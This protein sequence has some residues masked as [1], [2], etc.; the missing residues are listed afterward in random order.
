[1]IDWND[2]AKA[3]VSAYND[4]A[5]ENDLAI[6]AFFEHLTN[7]GHTQPK[8]VADAVEYYG[9]TFV[10]GQWTH[11]RC[12]KDG[13]MFFASGETDSDNW[14]DSY[15][16]CTRAEFEAYVK[17]KE[18][19]HFKAT[20]ENLEKIA[21]DAQGDFVEFEEGKKWTHTYNQG[22]MK[23]KII[24]TKTD[25]NGCVVVL[26]DFEEYQLIEPEDLKPI[27]PKLA[28]KQYDAC[29]NMASHFNIDPAEFDEYMSKFD[30]ELT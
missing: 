27:K 16:V 13:K 15:L 5:L 17:E 23:C 10:A 3:A 19:P 30:S 28:A 14:Q 29:A 25:F 4:W 12:G 26:N 8:T 1:M 20:R 24:Q 22:E 7:N 21:K 6:H 18:K 2:N 11:I 9:K